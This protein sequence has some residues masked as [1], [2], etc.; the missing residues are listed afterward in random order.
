[1]VT[2]CSTCLQFRNKQ[3]KEILIQ[4]DIPSKVWVKV[5]TDLFNL[6]KNDYLIIV[7]YFSKYFEIAQL[8]DTQSD[9]IISHRKSIFAR[10]GMPEIVIGHNGPQFLSHL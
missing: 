7:D 9:T 6:F 5:G 3:Q 2:S 1:M 8:P 4:F 10:H